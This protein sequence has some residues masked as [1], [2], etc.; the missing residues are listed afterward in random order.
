MIIAIDGNIAAGKSTVF[1][2][3]EK[4][5]PDVE[6]ILEPVQ[7]WDDLLALYY[8]DPQTWSLALNLKVLKCFHDISERPHENKIVERSPLSCRHVFAQLQYN[9][10]KFDKHQWDLFKEYYGILGWKP[11][12]VIFIETPAAK[13]LE[14]VEKRGR[15]CELF[16][17]LDLEYLKRIEYQYD[18][19]I[20]ILR[21]DYGIPVVI[22]DGTQAIEK[23]AVDVVAAASC[24]LTREKPPHIR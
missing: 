22:V 3:L 24:L 13:C 12:A 11:D 21:S 7:D 9:D 17:T 15:T 6:T 14:R 16:G 5:F 2:E 18:N 1:H 4:V 10:G 20:K 8:K 23:V 19:L